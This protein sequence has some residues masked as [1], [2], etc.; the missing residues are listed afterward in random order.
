MMTKSTELMIKNQM[1]T[2]QL[3]A[4]IVGNS[5]SMSSTRKKAELKVITD[6]MEEVAQ[7]I[8]EG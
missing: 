2:N 3:L 6:K 5:N 8:E 4:M 1:I 7:E